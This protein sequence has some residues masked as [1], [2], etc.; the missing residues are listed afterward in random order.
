MTMKQENLDEDLTD[1]KLAD[2]QEVWLKQIEEQRRSNLKKYYKFVR[3]CIGCQKEY[4][5]DS[6]YYT[7]DNKYCPVCSR[8]I[9]KRYPPHQN[10]NLKGGILEDGEN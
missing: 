7:M 2:S 4:G 1:A 3:I 10:H 9:N 8:S 5:L 6:D